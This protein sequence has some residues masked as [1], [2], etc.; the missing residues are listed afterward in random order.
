LFNRVPLAVRSTDTGKLNAL[1]PL[2]AI[3]VELVH[4]ITFDAALHVQFAAL[5]PPKVTT[6]FAM[7]RPAGR[8]STIVIVPELAVFPVFATVNKYVV[9]PPGVTV[10]TPS[11]LASVKLTT[12]TVSLSTAHPSLATPEPVH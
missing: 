1:V 3:A 4:V 12:L 9:I 11:V 10:V 5:A 7:V 2:A 8:T 6:P